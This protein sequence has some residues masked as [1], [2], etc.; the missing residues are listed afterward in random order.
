[1]TERTPSTS[2]PSAP[3][4]PAVVHKNYVY[5]LDP[6]IADNARFVALKGYWDEKR[7]ARPMPR[8][9]DI[10]PIELRDHLGSLVMI[11]VLPGRTDFRM[12]LIGTTIA[13][14]YG[15][16]STGKLLSELKPADPAWWRFCDEL[17]R[18]VAERAVPARAQGD[19]RMVGR[20]YRRFDSLLLP[21]DAGDGTVGRILAEQLFF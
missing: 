19:L 3:Q 1:M 9:A 5:A 16:D 10:D 17:Y 7:G 21:L 13:A 20:D 8:R 11:E 12:R 4:S 15:R 6:D 14:A 2:I 18:A